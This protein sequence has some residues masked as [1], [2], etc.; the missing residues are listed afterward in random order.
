MGNTSF[1]FSQ[2]YFAVCRLIGAGDEQRGVVGGGRLVGERPGLEDLYESGLQLRQG[3]DHLL[4]AVLGE[5]DGED[6]V[7]D[8][9]DDRVI[10]L[11]GWGW[12][13][14]RGS[15]LNRSNGRAD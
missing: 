11:I 7:A 4:H 8:D 2:R 6:I 10:G 1:I 12:Q 5:V 9:I 3:D 14:K 15:C 13:T